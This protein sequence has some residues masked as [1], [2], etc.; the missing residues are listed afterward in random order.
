MEL[1]GLIYC[2]QNSV[3]MVLNLELHKMWGVFYKLRNWQFLKKDSVSL[4]FGNIL[5][6][7]ATVSHDLFHHCCPWKLKV[8]TM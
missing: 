7:S 8:K 6:M 4:T 3:K 1:N 5:M 2:R